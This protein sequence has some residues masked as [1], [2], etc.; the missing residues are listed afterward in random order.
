MSTWRG[1]LRATPL[2]DRDHPVDAVVLH[3]LRA[4]DERPQIEAITAR[5]RRLLDRELEPRDLAGPDVLG[6]LKRD[7][8][9]AGPSGRGRSKLSVAAER[10]RFVLPRLGRPRAEVR[11][12]AHASG[13]PAERSAV[14]ERDDRGGR[15]ARTERRIPALS[16]PRRVEAAHARRNARRRSDAR[17]DAPR[18]R[19]HGGRGRG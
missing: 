5:R 9:I 10:R 19:A 14:V 13:H 15:L 8:V 17:S 12:L 2:L 6:G 1:R 16:E 4:L 3:P 18:A 7:A 11:D